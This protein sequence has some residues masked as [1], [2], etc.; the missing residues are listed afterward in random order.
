MTCVAGYRD[1][2]DVCGL[3]CDSAVTTQSYQFTAL[4]PK[5]RESG[6]LCWAVAGIFPPDMPARNYPGTLRGVK[7]LARDLQIAMMKSNHGTQDE[8]G[9]FSVPITAV[10]IGPGIGPYLL[11]PSGE[12]IEPSN[13]LAATGSGALAA[14]GA[15]HF[16]KSLDADA[17][18]ALSGAFEAAVSLD[19]FTNGDGILRLMAKPVRKKKESNAKGNTPRR[20]ASAT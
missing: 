9:A 16:A 11:G 10:C 14:L 17:E 4:T 3:I 13:G 1:A 2:N 5:M 6:K 19:P 7:A 12:V 8:D 15:L 18:A 20:R